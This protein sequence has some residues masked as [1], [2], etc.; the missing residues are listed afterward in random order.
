[1]TID[2]HIRRLFVDAYTRDIE[3]DIHLRKAADSFVEGFVDALVDGNADA[4]AILA[5][6][7]PGEVLALARSVAERS[8]Y[9]LPPEHREE[10]R[11]T[12]DNAWSDL[13]RKLGEVR[14][15]VN[16]QKV[17]RH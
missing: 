16:Q 5:C 15:M 9:D 7:T 1:M 4:D 3:I 14:T 6:E 8:I 17:T 11:A 10:A 2:Q 13:K 12:I